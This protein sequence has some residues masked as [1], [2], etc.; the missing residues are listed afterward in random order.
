MRVIAG[1]KGGRKLLD[2][3]FEHIRPTADLVKQAMFNKIA[4][5][6]E[7]SVV[8]D[9]FC[10]TGALGIEALSRCVE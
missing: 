9:L 5:D 4:F 7:G 3:K 8:L 10:A 6:I 1:S 2:N